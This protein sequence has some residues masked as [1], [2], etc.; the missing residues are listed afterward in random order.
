LSTQIE[1]DKPVIIPTVTDHDEWNYLNTLKNSNLVGYPNSA[2]QGYYARVLQY[3]YPQC[4]RVTLTATTF[5]V[6]QPGISAV[7]VRLTSEQHARQCLLDA[8]DP[9][10]PGDITKKDWLQILTDEDLLPHL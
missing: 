10:F 7:P 6:L 9:H 4:Q 5:Q 1:G 8:L 2:D 3:K